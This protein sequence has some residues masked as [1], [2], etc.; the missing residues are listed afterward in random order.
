[1]LNL[2]TWLS[3]ERLGDAPGGK[4]AAPPMVLIE[5]LHPVGVIL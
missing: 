1:M 5:L 3:I 4:R 2:L